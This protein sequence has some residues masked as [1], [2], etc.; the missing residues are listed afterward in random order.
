M[1]LGIFL[2]AAVWLGA[3]RCYVVCPVDISASCS[4]SRLN[5]WEDSL[6][7]HD[8]LL[9]SFVTTFASFSLRKKCQFCRLCRVLGVINFFPAWHLFSWWSTNNS[10]LPNILVFWSETE[11]G[12]WFPEL[13]LGDQGRQVGHP[14]LGSVLRWGANFNVS[15]LNRKQM[16]TPTKSI[17]LCVCAWPEECYTRD[18]TWV[19]LSKWVG[20]SS[21]FETKHWSQ[22]LK[23][24]CL[25]EK[26]WSPN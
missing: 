20:T 11:K 14:V 21:F 19:W 7:I 15:K 9:S 4:A 6:R 8:F 25:V 16:L 23:T 26:V 2:N 3:E 22:E 5:W 24:D 13:Q 12:V 17:V 18:Q 10:K 1:P